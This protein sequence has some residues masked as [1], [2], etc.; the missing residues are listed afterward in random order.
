MN[1]NLV[2]ENVV[3]KYNY[4]YYLIESICNIES[5][6]SVKRYGIKVESYDTNNNLV[7]TKTVKDI[8]GSKE[9]MLKGIK[10]LKN[11]EVT[12][13]TLEDVILDNIY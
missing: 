9:K 1:E 12:P 11:L 7:D 10:V 5:L 3:Q 2:F 13:I 4:K 6:G 8:F